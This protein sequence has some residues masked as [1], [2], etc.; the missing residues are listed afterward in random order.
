MQGSL[1]A[2]AQPGR[3]AGMRDA[4]GFVVVD[5]A[6][7]ATARSGEQQAQES[8]PALPQSRAPLFAPR[9][10]P[11]PD[12]AAALEEQQEAATAAAPAQQAATPRLPLG[13]TLEFFNVARKMAVE[14]YVWPHR[15]SCT[16]VWTDA[17][18]ARVIFNR[19]EKFCH[20][21]SLLGAGMR[22]LFQV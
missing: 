4:G 14:G 12:D 8:W 10:E 15:A 16:L 19:H 22:G 3:D 11:E 1:V 6:V 13:P 18:T 5:D 7:Q 2:R 21:A 20:V 17:G 9:P